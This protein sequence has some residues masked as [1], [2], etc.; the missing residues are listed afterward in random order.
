MHDLGKV[1]SFNIWGGGCGGAGN[2]IQGVTYTLDKKRA[3]TE[4]HP[5]TYNLKFY[6]FLSSFCLADT[7]ACYV[8]QTGLLFTM[9]PRLV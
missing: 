8:A 2:D 4:P 5:Q 9:K 1:E 3:T 6:G 7:G